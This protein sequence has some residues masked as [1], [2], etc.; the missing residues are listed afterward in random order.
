[1][2]K[3]MAVLV[4]VV[5]MSS[6]TYN[7]Y[8]NQSNK[9]EKD[10]KSNEVKQSED[11]SSLKIERANMINSCNAAY[12]C[13]FLKKDDSEH[14]MILVHN[15]KIMHSKTDK[16]ASRAAYF[17]LNSRVLNIPSQF[18]IVLVEENLARKVDCLTNEWSQWY[19]IDEQM[20]KRY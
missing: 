2:K 14:F 3:F 9:V 16:L 4:L 20:N 15:Y 7:R 19:S 11:M 6:C 12:D 5:M 13:H 17:C 10:I 1:M 18:Y 8:T